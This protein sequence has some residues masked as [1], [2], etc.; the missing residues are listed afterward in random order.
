MPLLIWVAG[1]AIILS[2]LSGL[3]LV[4]P[5]IAADGLMQTTSLAARWCECPAAD[6]GFRTIKTERASLAGSRRN[7]LT[8]SLSGGAHLPNS[9]NAGRLKEFQFSFDFVRQPEPAIRVVF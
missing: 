9:I 3:L 6:S 8:C 4:W 5:L 1:I 2:S 7:S